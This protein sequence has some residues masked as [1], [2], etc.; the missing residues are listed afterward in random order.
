MFPPKYFLV[1]LTMK[2]D[3]FTQ[4]SENC[5][6]VSGCEDRMELYTLK[7]DTDT[8][9]ENENDNLE[10]DILETEADT[11]ENVNPTQ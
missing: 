6:T 5:I 2:L 3:I 1:Y 11:E 4:R 8:D 7:A 10:H 9:H